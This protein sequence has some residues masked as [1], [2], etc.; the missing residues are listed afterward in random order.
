MLTVSQT[1]AE[2]AYEFSF[3]A[4]S[5]GVINLASYH[6]QPLVIVNTASQ[7]GFTPQYDGLQAIYE[8]Y[9]EAGLVVIALPSND[10]GRQEKGTAEEIKEFCEVNFNITFPMADKI[11]VKGDDAH[12]FYNWASQQ[13]GS[14]GKPRWNF[15]K[16][17]IGR[18]GH[19]ADWYAST[20]APESKKMIKAIEELL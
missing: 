3:P 16:F 11:K 4:L 9:Q 17:L 6:G 7:C 19:I 14:L 2:T 5:G 8:R 20:T 15:H 10:F 12:P 13:V 18:D 1:K